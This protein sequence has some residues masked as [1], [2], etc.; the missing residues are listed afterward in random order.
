V[1]NNGLQQHAPSNA[2]RHRRGDV[3]QS[4]DKVQIHRLFKKP[5]GKAQKKLKAEA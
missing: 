1:N 2:T 5:A 4:V 3:Y